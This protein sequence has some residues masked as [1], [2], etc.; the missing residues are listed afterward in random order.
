MVQG[1][2]IQFADKIKTRNCWTLARL[3]ERTFIL[4]HTFLIRV[5]HIWS[6][7]RTFLSVKWLWLCWR[8]HMLFLNLLHPLGQRF[9]W[10]WLLIIRDRSS[11]LIKCSVASWFIQYFP[12]WCATSW[13]LF[14]YL[15]QLLIRDTTFHRLFRTNLFGFYRL[16]LL[17]IS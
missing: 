13:L 12:A 2:V 16:L 17:L 4:L 5:T 15:W 6:W 1:F 7:R 11:L 10:R 3:F 14:G 8:T 9:T